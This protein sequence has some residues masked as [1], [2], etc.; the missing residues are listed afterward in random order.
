MRQSGL[1]ALALL[2]VVQATCAQSDTVAQ[3]TAVYLHRLQVADGGF[4]PTNNAPSNGSL[5]ATLASLRGLKYFHDKVRDRE[6]CTRFVRS[7][8]DPVAGGFADQ[9]RAQVDVA[10]TAVGVMAA[11][12][13]GLP[14]AEYKEPTIRYLAEHARGFEDIRIAAA[15]FEVTGW[16][17][18][19]FEW[20][21]EQ[22]AT[23]R[24]PDGTY[25]QGDG[26]ARMTGSAV[27]SVLRLGGRVEQREN[28]VRILKAGQCLD[29]GFGKDGTTGSDLESCYRVVRAFSMLK[30]RPDAQRC[31]DFVA[32]CHNTDGG[33][34]VAP[35][36]P[37]S[38][39]ATYYATI[40][41]HWLQQP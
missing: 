33:Y 2:L 36:E 34:G 41:R 32:R 17:S 12:E 37:S 3:T 26:Q 35:G 30:E 5:R 20:W 16:S 15:V 40:I 29:G 14:L 11:A 6:R 38:A 24:N 22:I 23:L 21:L 19:R 27:V 28:V 1:A 8:F 18:S 39:S 7:C 13:L 10:C 25:G 4:R 9:P 31:L